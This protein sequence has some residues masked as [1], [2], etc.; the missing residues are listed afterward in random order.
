MQ[1][2]DTNMLY[3]VIGGFVALVLVIGLL[4]SDIFRARVTKDG[5]DVEASKHSK[6]VTNIK[7][8]KNNAYVELEQNIVDNHSAEPMLAVLI[9]QQ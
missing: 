5:L 2:I 7:G 1:A 4:K 9:T 8:I 3:L 6:T